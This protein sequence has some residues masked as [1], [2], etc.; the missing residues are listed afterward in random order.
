MYKKADSFI[1]TK[2]ALVS[3]GS[4]SASICLLYSIDDDD[5]VST[6]KNVNL[7]N[8]FHHLGKNQSY[9]VICFILNSKLTPLQGK[10][11]NRSVNNIEHLKMICIW[12]KSDCSSDWLLV[13][14]YDLNIIS[15]CIPG[16]RYIAG[17]FNQRRV[18]LDIVFAVGIVRKNHL[19]ERNNMN[20]WS[21]KSVKEWNIKHQLVEEFFGKE[22]STDT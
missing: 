9:T 3:R 19:G 10:C 4:L 6:T 21:N 1:P 14:K 7:F 12:S 16:A 17:I 22:E 18:D 2:C 20:V 15:A 5:V 13:Q 11:G 8:M